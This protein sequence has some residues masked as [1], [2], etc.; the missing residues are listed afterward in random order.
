LIHAADRYFLGPSHLRRLFVLSETVRRRLYAHLRVRSEALYPPPPPRAYRCDG[1]GDFV[2]TASRLTPH[3]RVD[4]LLRALATAQGRPLRAVIAGDGPDLTRLRALARELGVDDR[5]AFA[6]RVDEAALLEYYAT[7][8]AVCFT[9]L[10][11]DFGFVT[12]E[13]FAS[14]KPVVAC[15]DSGG[16]A[17][18]VTDGASG[19]L[20]EPDPAALA[21]ALTRLAHDRALAERMGTAG[22][23]RVAELSW[24]STVARLLLV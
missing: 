18:L 19:L 5:V 21:S 1:Y 3:K 14:R 4:L 16:P 7:C 23:Q 12:A 10:A 15:T 9:P 6:G 13:A 20:C 8:R 11:E 24:P 17:E 22:A 2:F